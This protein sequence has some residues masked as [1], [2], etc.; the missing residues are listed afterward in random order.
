MIAMDM[1]NLKVYFGKNGT[2]ETSGDP[3]SG[4]TGTG[5]IGDLTA[6]Q[7]YF[8]VICPRGGSTYCN[9]GN[10]A[11]TIASGNSRC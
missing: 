6:D 10:P 7:D 1:D 11:F 3:E 2:W 5:S 4:A 8:F 9:F